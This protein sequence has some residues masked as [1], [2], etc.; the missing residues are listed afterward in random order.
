M[1]SKNISKATTTYSKWPDYEGYEDLK[2]FTLEQ[3]EAYRNMLLEKSKPQ[4]E[5]IKKH[6]YPLFK[7]GW[8]DVIELGSGNGRLPIAL[9]LSGLTDSATGVELSKSRHEF[10]EKWASDWGVHE[11]VFMNSDFTTLQPLHEYELSICITGCFQYLYPADS[12]APSSVLKLMAQSGMSWFELYRKPPMG[13]TWHKLPD[14]DRWKYILDEYTDVHD[15]VNHKKIF[16]GHNGEVDER[17]ENLAYYD[18]P[19]FLSHLKKAG[20]GEILWAKQNA[21]TMVVLAT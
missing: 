15:W 4:V 5:F 8:F 9:E 3:L 1:Q 2:N 19:V 18:M 11:A 20:F 17:E 7:N 14:G 12:E 16:V 13:H 10:A 6:V 21:K